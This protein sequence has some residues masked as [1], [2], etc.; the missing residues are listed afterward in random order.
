MSLSLGKQRSPKVR[1]VWGCVGMVGD[2]RSKSVPP[3]VFS[4]P[5]MLRK[6]TAA[7]WQRLPRLRPAAGPVTA[8]L[9]H[10]VRGPLAVPP[11]PER[12][13]WR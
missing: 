4:G 3:T 13:A 5:R 7:A 12:A 1:Q 2:K 8:P 6:E 9:S 10:D 11:G